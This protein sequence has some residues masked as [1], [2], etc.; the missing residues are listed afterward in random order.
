MF[1]LVTLLRISVL[2]RLE[3]LSSARRQALR[4]KRKGSELREQKFS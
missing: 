4:K 1:I 3:I 2:P